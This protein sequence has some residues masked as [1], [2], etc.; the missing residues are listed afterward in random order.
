MTT[1]WYDDPQYW[2]DDPEEVVA[3]VTWFYDGTLEALV[4][5]V[6]YMFEKPWKWNDEYEA[7]ITERNQT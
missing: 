6:I 2:Y 3:F 4:S 7:F 5:E 1:N